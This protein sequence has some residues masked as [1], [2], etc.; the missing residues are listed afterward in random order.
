MSRN[1]IL[2]ILHYFRNWAQDGRLNSTLSFPSCTGIGLRCTWYDRNTA[3]TPAQYLL[4]PTEPALARHNLFG[5]TVHRLSVNR[6][7]HL[8]QQHGIFRPS[9]PKSR[10]RD[11]KGLLDSD[12]KKKEL[13]TRTLSP[14]FTGGRTP[15]LLITIL[16]IAFFSSQ[17]FQKSCIFN[18]PTHTV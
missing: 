17:E 3:D 7:S 2:I 13:T 16:Q 12:K 4:T 5:F 18:F 10:A 14:T 9:P 11:S 6:G 15:L 8:S 1:K